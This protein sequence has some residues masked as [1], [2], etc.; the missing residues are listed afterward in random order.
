MEV[1][2]A[3]RLEGLQAE[4]IDE[5]QG[6]AGQGLEAPVVGVGS[7]GRLQ[8]GEQAALGGEEH[9]VVAAGGLV[10]QG[11]GQV[12]LAGAAGAGDEH[13]DLFGDEAAGGQV[14]DLGLVDAGIVGEVE[15]A[16]RLL[17]AA[18]GAADAPG[19]LLVLAAGDLVLDEQGEELGVGQL[20]LHRLAVAEGQALQQPGPAQALELRH[21]LGQGLQQRRGTHG[22]SLPGSVVVGVGEPV[23]PGAAEAPLAGISGGQRWGRGRRQG[24]RARAWKRPS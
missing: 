12:A 17:R 16:Q 8:G 22:D 2:V 4:I 9:V 5:E 14:E 15:I 13:R 3:G 7:P 6:H 23:D 11:L 20:P 24:T 19:E 18:A 1:L 21:Q 10:P